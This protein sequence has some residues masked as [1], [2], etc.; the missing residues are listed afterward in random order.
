MTR[1]ARIEAITQV[2]ILLIMGVM[3]ASA[4][5]THIHD[6]AVATASRSYRRGAHHPIG[7]LRQP[8]CVFLTL[9]VVVTCYK[10]LRKVTT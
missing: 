4:S 5:L 6:L 9:A 10:D 3:A 2:V 8:F 1:T 7:A